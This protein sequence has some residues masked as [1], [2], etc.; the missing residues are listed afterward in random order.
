MRVATQVKSQNVSHHLQQFNVACSR[1]LE[2]ILKH[3]MNDFKKL[4]RTPKPC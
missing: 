1:N 4:A 3:P 2:K